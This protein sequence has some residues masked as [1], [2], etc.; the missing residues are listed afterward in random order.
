MNILNLVKAE[1]LQFYKLCLNRSLGEKY[2]DKIEYDKTVNLRKDKEIRARSK[3]SCET[4]MAQLKEIFEDVPGILAARVTGS[5]PA[6]LCGAVLQDC[7][8]VMDEKGITLTAKPL[9]KKPDI[10]V[11]IIVKEYGFVKSDEYYKLRNKVQAMDKH[12]LRVSLGYIDRRTS[13]KYSTR[14]VVRW[15]FLKNQVILTGEEFYKKES[16]AVWAHLKKHN[17]QKEMVAFVGVRHLYY[18]L[19]NLIRYYGT[20]S[21][22]ISKEENPDLYCANDSWERTRTDLFLKE[23]YE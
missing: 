8:E 18:A 17:R 12:G 19:K 11:E 2:F 1:D 5:A 23:D 7:E 21:I 16:E 3:D 4:I 15:G 13:C 20:E 22:Y 14:N 6:G 10:D 9:A